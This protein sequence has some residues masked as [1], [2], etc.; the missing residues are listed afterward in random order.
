M[1]IPEAISPAK[2]EEIINE[3]DQYFSR[4]ANIPGEPLY[5]ILKGKTFSMEVF[6]RT[7]LQA[8]RARFYSLTTDIT[9]AKKLENAIWNYLEATS[10]AEY[11]TEFFSPEDGA[12]YLNEKQWAP[13]IVEDFIPY[14]RL[15]YVMRPDK[16]E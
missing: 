9:E 16:K 5:D 12:E 15:M 3:F 13:V 1:K 8:V 6:Y 14:A 7:F 2:Q 4:Q 11:I 10:D